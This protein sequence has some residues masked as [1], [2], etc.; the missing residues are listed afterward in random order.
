MRSRFMLVLGAVAACWATVAAAE[1]QDR[2]SPQAL[3]EIIPGHSTKEDL[4]A[5]LGAP[6]RVA[7]FNDCGQAMDGQGDETWEYR[8]KAPSGAYRLHVEFDDNGIVRLIAE[9]PDKSGE[10]STIAVVAPALAAMCL[11]M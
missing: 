7:Q 9:I 3:A 10:D 4:Q 6:W 2:I 5:L 1:T 8:G 11:S